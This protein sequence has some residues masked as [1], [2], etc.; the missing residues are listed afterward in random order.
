MCGRGWVQ[1]GPYGAM[2]TSRPYCRGGRSGRAQCR[3]GG[4]LAVSRSW[5][6]GI[7]A[8]TWGVGLRHSYRNRVPPGSTAARGTEV[9][10]HVFSGAVVCHAQ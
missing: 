6:Q 3:L 10:S 8:Y 1:V 5:W 4:G 7:V 9:A 2:H